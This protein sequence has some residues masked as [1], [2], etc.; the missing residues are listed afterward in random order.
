MISYQYFSA[1][2]LRCKCGECSIHEMSHSFMKDIV[3][4][5]RLCGF[6]LTVTSAYRCPAYN[7]SISSTGRDGPHTTG[8]AIDFQVSGKKSHR[9][10]EVAMTL[11][12]KGI[13]ISQKGPHESRFIHIDNLS[14]EQGPRPWVWTY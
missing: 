14:S 7:D 8:L 3:L 10:L 13:G 11:K 12:F 9:L 4:L 1:K 5:R 2:E 6:P